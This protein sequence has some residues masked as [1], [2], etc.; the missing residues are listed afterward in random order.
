MRVLYLFTRSRKGEAARVASGEQHDNSFYGM[1]RMGHFGVDAE[2]FEVED[3]VPA[4]VADLIKKFFTAY[5]VHLPFYLRFRAY[6]VVFAWTSYGTQLLHT[7]YPFKKPKWVMYDFSILGL[8]GNGTRLKQRVFK[9]M[10]ARAAGIVTISKAE[11]IRLQEMFPHLKDRI[12][13]IPLGVDTAFFAPRPVEQIPQIFAPGFDP[14]RDYE[15]LFRATADSGAQVVVS[16]SRA[17][18][19]IGELPVHVRAEQFSQTVYLEELAKSQIVVLSLDISSGINDAAGCTTLV[20][21]MAMGKAV[22]A[23]RTPTMESY[24]ENGLNGLLVEAKDAAGLR[25]AIQD[26]LHDDKKREQLGEK[27]RGFVEINCEAEISAG[28]MAQFFRKIT[29]NGNE[30]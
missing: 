10:T 19:D 8:I 4:W 24:I 28:K 20:E 9:W 1:L 21:A 25:D 30:M 7:L 26:L 27:A 12:E 13:F 18:D 6:D 2:N 29:A 5:A 11:A 22:I 23:T 3:Y 16:R 15:T 14:C 17:I